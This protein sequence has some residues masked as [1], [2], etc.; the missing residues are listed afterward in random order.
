[1]VRQG[2]HPLTSPDLRAHTHHL[3]HAAT[4]SSAIVR[5]RAL[6]PVCLHS[7]A[8]S[9]HFSRA[10]G[11][12][13]RD[14][15]RQ[16][17]H[18]PH[19]HPGMGR[20][21]RGGESIAD[22]RQ[23]SPVTRRE[24]SRPASHT[25]IT[26]EGAR[27]PIPPRVRTASPRPAVQGQLIVARDSVALLP[28]PAGVVRRQGEV[29]CCRRPAAGGP[30]AARPARDGGAAAHGS[31]QP[32]LTRGGPPPV[33]ICG[34]PPVLPPAAGLTACRWRRADTRTRRD[35]RQSPHPCP[36]GPPAPVSRDWVG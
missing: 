3:H 1:M 15:G 16:L 33:A 12:V 31:A 17:P 14:M 9:V 32:A 10:D 24:P 4:T 30:A 27:M 8:R 36:S 13:R 28:G 29:H 18:L 6:L 20:G 19:H 34:G 23:M 5:S 35:A 22:N 21:W 26:R 11:S 25:W 7:V 2:F